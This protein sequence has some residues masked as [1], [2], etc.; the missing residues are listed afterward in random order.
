MG[1]NRDLYMKSIQKI[2]DNHLQNVTQYRKDT[3]LQI[4]GQFEATKP[5]LISFLLY[6]RQINGIKNKMDDLNKSAQELKEF[7]FLCEHNLI[8]F[9]TVTGQFDVLRNLFRDKSELARLLDLIDE[10]E[11]EHNKAMFNQ[12]SLPKLTQPAA[13]SSS[14]TKDWDEGVYGLNALTMYQ[15]YEEELKHLTYTYHAKQSKLYSQAAN[16]ELNE[17]EQTIRTV[18]KNKSMDPVAKA[19]CLRDLEDLRERISREKTIYENMTERFTRSGVPNADDAELLHLAAKDYFNQVLSAGEVLKRH[20]HLAPE[21]A[22]NL[23]N[24][25]KRMERTRLQASFNEQDYKQKSAEI[26]AKIEH[27]KGAVVAQANEN[28]TA[29]LNTIKTFNKS[30]LDEDLENELNEAIAQLKTLQGKLKTAENYNVTKELLIQCAKEVDKIKQIT[31]P[32]VPDSLKQK[33]NENL[34]VF[35]KAAHSPP[36]YVRIA[37]EGHQSVDSQV[38]N[39]IIQSYATL[40]TEEARDIEQ[41][42]GESNGFDEPSSVNSSSLERTTQDTRESTRFFRAAIQR[43]NTQSG[44]I[45]ISPEK[46]S[47]FQDAIEKKLECIGNLKEF[48]ASDAVMLGK[49]ERLEVLL[50]NAAQL[51]FI[52]VNEIEL[53]EIYTLSQELSEDDLTLQASC[54][55]LVDVFDFLEEASIAQF[56][57]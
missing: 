18:R 24:H 50:N 2:F 4:M 56:R 48:E 33:F 10:I 25:Q 41:T 30:A 52:Q 46:Q 32:I 20:E 47:L 42:I 27:F 35:Y 12:E 51:G 37:P 55:Q 8:F 1:K 49:V 15:Y 22:R 38:P 14:L 36:E 29:I 23:Q 3:G 19:A 53:K 21:I 16:H 44:L 17:L 43:N 45:A 34:D 40:H 6:L 26:T 54:E 11:K 39:E 28:I 57:A 7:N 5:L 13:Q 31:A 9:L